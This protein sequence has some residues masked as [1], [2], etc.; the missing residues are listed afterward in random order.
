MSGIRYIR[1]RYFEVLTDIFCDGNSS[2]R[3]FE[4]N[5]LYQGSLFRDSVY[6]DIEWKSLYDVV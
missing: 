4:G 3:D 6:R 1:V 2:Y 5:S